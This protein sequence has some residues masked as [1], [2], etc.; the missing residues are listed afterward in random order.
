M[1]KRM[2]EQE[3]EQDQESSCYQYD[4]PSQPCH[5]MAGP[6]AAANFFCFRNTRN[7]QISNTI[8]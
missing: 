3:Q 6:D 5:Q 7:V 2:K 4:S 1:L 8:I